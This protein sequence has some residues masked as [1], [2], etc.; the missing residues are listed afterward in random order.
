MTFEMTIQVRVSDFL[1]GQRWYEVLLNR[2]PD[3]V[4][5]EGFA[6]WEIIPG[7]W[8]QVAEG[9]PAP[10]SG[11]IRLGLTDLEGEKERL[12]RELNI[13]PFEILCRKEVPVRWASLSDPWGNGIGF[14]EYI[15]KKEERERIATL[16]RV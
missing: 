11:P 7:C 8:L 4:P 13:E 2:K 10:G 16:Q 15:D 9:E 3:F 1:K 6:E 14:F 12:I 5:H